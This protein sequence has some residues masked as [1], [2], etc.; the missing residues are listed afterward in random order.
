VITA[1]GA[2]TLDRIT[3]VKISSVALPLPTG[4]SDAKVLTGRQQPMT[5]IAVLFAEISTAAGLEGIGISYAK[6]AGGPGQFAH[7]RELAPVLLGED[8]SDIAKIWDS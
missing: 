5:E 8:P 6:R 1:L 2:A 4:I 7:A 3:E